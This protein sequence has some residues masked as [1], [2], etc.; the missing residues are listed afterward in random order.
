[1]TERLAG[2]AAQIRN[3]QQLGAIVMA[4]R[5]M[6]A[7]RAQQGRA[8]L[9]GNEAY[10][11]T[12]ARAIGR[13]L[14]VQ[15]GRPAE[16]ARAARAR[17]VVLFTAEQGFAGAYNDR[18]FAAFESE[19]RDA[20]TFVIGT[21][22]NQLAAERDI[23]VHWSAAM[24]TQPS[25][26]PRLADAIAEALFER[27]AAGTVATVDMIHARAGSGGRVQA[28]RRSLFPVDFTRFAAERRRDQPLTNLAPA[29]LLERLALEY[30]YA[31]LCS[32]TSQAF[33]AE[34]EARMMM[35][36]SAK[37]NIDSKLDTLT[38]RERELRQQEITAEVIELTAGAEAQRV[39]A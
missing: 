21:R 30:V 27:I 24:V 23:A 35:M 37:A 29:V 22:G 38:R 2:V 11:A 28:V 12:V 20:V 3:V 16:P 4:M 33:T 13:A 25:A 36:A 5:G 10:T 14:T 9:A 1:M 8:L 34:N 7:S 19:L 15:D 26:I 32:A 31:E 18:I 6:A 39:G 17:A